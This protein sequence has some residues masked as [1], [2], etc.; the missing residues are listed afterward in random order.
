MT[1]ISHRRKFDSMQTASE[2]VRVEFFSN[3]QD[4]KNI[5]R[6]FW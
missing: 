2:H 3:F 4:I 5:E 1:S 6:K